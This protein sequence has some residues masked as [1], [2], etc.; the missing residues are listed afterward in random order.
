VAAWLIAIAAKPGPL[1]GL[2]VWLLACA[3]FAWLG[4]VSIAEIRAL[5]AR[6]LGRG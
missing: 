1:V 2:A 6:A 4:S 5:S 3:S